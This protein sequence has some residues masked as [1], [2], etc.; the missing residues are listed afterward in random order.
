M[1]L[2]RYAVAAGLALL[3]TLALLLGMQRL[4]QS[5][6]DA[7]AASE[8]RKIADI[9][10]SKPT[11]EERRKL[12][13]PDKPEQPEVMPP[14]PADLR[15]SVDA[16]T[17]TVAMDMPKLSGPSIGMGGDFTRDSDFIPVYVPQPDYPP[18]AL[19]RGIEG[20]AVVE[21]TITTTGSVRDVKL[22][23]ESPPN[24]G[25][26]K[27]ALRAA[28]KLKYNPRVI[29]GVAEEVPGVLYKFS[30]KIAR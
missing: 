13:K 12:R 14:P 4:I 17:D 25:F 10:Q 7:P 27:Y 1:M 8:G 16:P 30:F 26:G 18:M 3:M 9:W 19:R 5:M 24:K 15:A 21:V 11:I 28:E 6:G 22:L 23:E 29:N 2:L 20:Y